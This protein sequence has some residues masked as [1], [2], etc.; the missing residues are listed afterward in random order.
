M[1]LENVLIMR[2]EYM[3]ARKKERLVEARSEV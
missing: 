3:N 2:S 1:L